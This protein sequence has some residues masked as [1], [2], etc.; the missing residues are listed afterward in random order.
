MATQVG[1][2]NQGRLV[3]FGSPR[4]IYEDPVSLYVASRLGTPRINVLPAD[5][6]AGAPSGAAVLV[7]RSEHIQQG[8]GKSAI[9]VRIEHLG[10]QTRLH[11]NLDGHDIV[12]LTDVHTQLKPGDPVAIQPRN[13]LYFDAAG[14]RIT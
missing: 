7:L 9:V 1:V 3:Q 10:D 6:F 11:L 8:E 2:L 5:L 12:T 13:A 4:E 14:D